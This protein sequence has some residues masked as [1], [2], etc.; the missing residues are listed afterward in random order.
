MLS[1]R[2]LVE[3]LRNFLAFDGMPLYSGGVMDA[4]PAEAVDAI[5]IGRE[6]LAAVRAYVETEHR[7]K[8]QKAH[9][10]DG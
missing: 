7:T 6:E 9:E 3:H 5:R 8:P 2:P 4:W 1:A 10:E